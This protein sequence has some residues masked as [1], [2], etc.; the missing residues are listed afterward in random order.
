MGNHSAR[1]NAGPARRTGC[2]GD[3][4]LILWDRVEEL[5]DRAPGWEALRVHRLHLLAARIRHRRGE[6][7]PPSIA[8]EWRRAALTSLAARTVLERIRDAH[9]G[10]LLLMKGPEVAA[11][12]PDPADRPF[13]DLDLLLDDPESAQA[14]LIAAGFVEIGAGS[15]HHLPALFWPEL[16][17]LIEL[18]RR[19]KSPPSLPRLGAGSIFA[20]AIPSRTGVDGVLA[21]DPAA[22]ALL[23]AAHSWSHDP[24]RR[25]RDMIDIAAT[26]AATDRS[27]IAAR[28]DE[29]GWRHLWSVTAS[30]TDAVLADDR[31][32]RMLG[33]WARH[34]LAARDRRVVEHQLSRLLAP[35]CSL[36]PSRAPGGVIG[37]IREIVAR[38]NDERWTQKLRRVRWAISD[39]LMAES[40]HELRGPEAA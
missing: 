11:S 33:P 2:S 40:T 25:L 21:P 17:L 26:I 12:Y 22:H 8:A 13:R 20:A 9:G 28:A 24:L 16:P 7:L 31:L 35:L 4:Q 38:R 3:R 37:G 6:A 34:L 10:R 39:A 19:P 15:A 27:L 1:L 30:A 14:D 23:L 32:P 36:P 5:I 18:H 29:W